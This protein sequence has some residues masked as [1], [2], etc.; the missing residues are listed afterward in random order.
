[1]DFP[2]TPDTSTKL[3]LEVT[4]DGFLDYSV[5]QD[6]QLTF[7]YLGEIS[8]NLRYVL[9]DGTTKIEPHRTKLEDYAYV[10]FSTFDAVSDNGRYVSTD[11]AYIAE[12]TQI[13]LVDSSDQVFLGINLAIPYIGEELSTFELEV[14]DGLFRWEEDSTQVT[15]VSASIDNGVDP[16][17]STIA[18]LEPNTSDTGMV[19]GNTLEIVYADSTV[20]YPA[21]G[22]VVK[23]IGLE[24]TY[25]FTVSNLE[26]KQIVSIGIFNYEG[27]TSKAISLNVPDGYIIEGNNLE[28]EVTRKWTIL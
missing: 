13:L 5:D 19:L 16:V 3:K 23:D 26:D 21:L 1:M 4:R 15:S 11:T 2:I 27:E 7:N 18:Y 14:D 20:D 17:E 12:L 6:V 24:S 8:G 22:N 28:L 25:T 9:T 10:E